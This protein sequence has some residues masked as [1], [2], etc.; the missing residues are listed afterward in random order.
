MTNF[1][2]TARA[3]YNRPFAKN[4]QTTRNKQATSTLTQMSGPVAPP[5][6]VATAHEQRQIK[7]IGLTLASMQR[8][9]SKKKWN[10]LRLEAERAFKELREKH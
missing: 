1:L 10:A 2:G 6:P 8:T 4:N 5:I 3:S 7:L 9:G